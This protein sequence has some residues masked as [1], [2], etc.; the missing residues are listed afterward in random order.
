MS[1][2]CRGLNDCAA[3]LFNY[4]LLS[5]FNGYVPINSDIFLFIKHTRSIIERSA[6]RKYLQKELERGSIRLSIRLPGNFDYS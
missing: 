2:Y 5:R 4:T 3:I 1:R 6:C